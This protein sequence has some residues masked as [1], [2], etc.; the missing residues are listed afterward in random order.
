M[1]RTLI[2]R[3]MSNA[4]EPIRDEE[5]SSNP[6]DPRVDISAIYW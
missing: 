1:Y 5:C 2:E 4:V 3:Q 6:G